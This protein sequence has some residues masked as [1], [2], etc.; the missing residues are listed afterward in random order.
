MTVCPCCLQEVKRR[1]CHHLYPKTSEPKVE[2][3]F[4]M[5]C[6]SC[7]L[8]LHKVFPNQALRVLGPDQLSARVNYV[9]G[10]GDRVYAGEKPRPAAPPPEEMVT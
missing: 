1:S 2:E 5:M 9:Y 3:E 6:K 10:N 4:V 8:W 7:H